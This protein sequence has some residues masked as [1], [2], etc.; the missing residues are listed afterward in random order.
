MEFR[1]YLSGYCKLKS[2]R[3]PLCTNHNFIRN[4]DNLKSILEGHKKTL[5]YAKGFG[6]STFHVFIELLQLVFFRTKNS[7][8][9]SRLRPKSVIRLSKV[10]TRIDQAILK[11]ISLGNTRLVKDIVPSKNAL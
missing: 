6:I 5:I 10:N 2:S 1:S 3:R 8:M 7:V 4:K 11:N 9:R